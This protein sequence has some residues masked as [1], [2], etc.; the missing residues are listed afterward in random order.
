MTAGKSKAKGKG[1]VVVEGKAGETEAESMARAFVGPFLRHG[2]VA[3][4]V[5][6]KMAGKLPGEPEFD[7]FGLQMKRLADGG[8]SGAEGLAHQ[9]LTAQALSLDAIFTEFARRS[10]LNMGDYINASERYMRLALKAQAGSRATLAELVKLHQPREQTVRHVHVNEGGQAVIADEFHH[11]TGGQ[12]NGQRGEQP[13]AKC[14]QGPALSGPDPLREAV[15][16][17]GSEGKATVPDARGQGQR[18]T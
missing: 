6:D 13:H 14:A 9:M 12:E 10:L 1:A 3:K 7:T 17:P 4:G 16:I 15:P 11:H 8:K 2:V 18:G 5:T